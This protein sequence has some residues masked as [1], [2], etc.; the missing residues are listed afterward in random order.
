MEGVHGGQE[1]SPVPS[2]A[3]VLVESTNPPG[4]LAQSPFLALERFSW[5]HTE[6]R[7][8]GVQLDSSM[9]SVSPAALM[10]PNVVS[11]MTS[12]QG[13]CSPALLCPVTAHE[14]LLVFHLDPTPSHS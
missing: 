5:L 13:W 1:N 10:D 11:Q 7:Q 14:L 12:L 8:A 3:Q 6:P 4:A 2:L 9:L